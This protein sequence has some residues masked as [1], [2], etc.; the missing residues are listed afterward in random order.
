MT[1]P[2]I[3]LSGN[4]R[5][6]TGGAFLLLENEHCEFSMIIDATEH[7]LLSEIGD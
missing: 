5:G 1:Q 6:I 3:T 7:N 4:N 2:L